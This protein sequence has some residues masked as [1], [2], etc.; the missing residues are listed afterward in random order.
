V[1]WPW[2]RDDPEQETAAE[3]ARRLSSTADDLERATLELRSAVTT[4]RRGE[5]VAP[6]EEH[7]R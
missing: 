1:R 3:L 2:Q 4:L 7:V 5:P 6:R